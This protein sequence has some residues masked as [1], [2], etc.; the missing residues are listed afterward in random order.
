MPDRDPDAPPGWGYNPASWP[1]RLPIIAAAVVGFVI[2]MYLALY[3]WGAFD[4][5]FEPFFGNDSHVILRESAVSQHA[6]AVFRVPDAFLGAL[7][8]LADAVAGAVGG[9]RRWRTMPWLVLLFGFFVGPLGAVS[10][11]LVI[12]Q[13]FSGGWCT[14]CLLTAVISVLMIGPAMDEV[15]ASLQHLARERRAGRSGWRALWGLGEPAAAP[16][17]RSA[18]G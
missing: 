8:Y 18:G 17:L 9:G 15:L 13:P 14:L 10:V 6:R 11:L 4:T 5:V 16:Q 3:Q 12:L 2:A 1:Q 7:G